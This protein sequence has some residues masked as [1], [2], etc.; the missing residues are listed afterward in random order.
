[1]EGDRSGE[2]GK[3]GGVEEMWEESERLRMLVVVYKEHMGG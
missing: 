3:Q 2:E 1:V